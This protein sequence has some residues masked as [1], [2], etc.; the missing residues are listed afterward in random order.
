MD[1]IRVRFG[2]VVRGRRHKLGISQEAFAALCEL[3][4]TYVGGIERGE[5]NV[6]LANIEKIAR[7]LRI[8]LS[9]LFR[10]M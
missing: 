8:P 5:R 10:N 4:R 2:K 6:A 3:D 7:A 9:E 1:D